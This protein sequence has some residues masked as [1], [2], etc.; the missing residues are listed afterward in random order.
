MTKPREYR[1]FLRSCDKKRFKRVIMCDAWDII[2]AVHPDE[3]WEKYQ[4]FAPAVL[5]N[6]E[7]NCFPRVDLADHPL[8]PD[9]GT[10]WRYLNSGFYMGER[11]AVLEI[12]ESM[13]LDK[14]PD[15]TR[16]EDGSWFN[17]NDQE[18]FTLAFLDQPVPMKLDTQ[19]AVVIAAHTSRLMEFDL[20][21]DHIVN[22]LSGKAPGV[23]HFNGDAKNNIMEHI[24]SH[25]ERKKNEPT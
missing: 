4:E 9:E 24:V 11:E 23:F 13:D 10:P 5:F 3:V 15:D 1:N 17:P 2:F 6:A 22:R 8:F 16:K 7:R 25:L 12:L 18:Y 14:I 19:T 20:S 21:G